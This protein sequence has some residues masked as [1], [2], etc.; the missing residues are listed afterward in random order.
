MVRHQSYREKAMQL[1]A[2]AQKEPD[3]ILRA[4]NERLAA[5]YM[6]LADRLSETEDEPPPDARSPIDRNPKK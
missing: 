6:G 1:L 3:P 5:S 2:R 4:D